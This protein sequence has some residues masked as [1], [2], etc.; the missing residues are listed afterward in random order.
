M[1]TQKFK[2]LCIDGGGIKGLYSARLLAK[3][4]EVFGCVI[5]DCFDILCGTSTGGTK[6]ILQV[7]QNE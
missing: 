7:T 6:E 2:I 5:S 4:E 3:F 1:K